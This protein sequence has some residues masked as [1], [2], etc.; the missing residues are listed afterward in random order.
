[1]TTDRKIS[2]EM[3]GFIISIVCLIIVCFCAHISCYTSF[4][5]TFFGDIVTIPVAGIAIII[6]WYHLLSD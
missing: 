4:G 2:K 3:N 6:S 1:M 5:S